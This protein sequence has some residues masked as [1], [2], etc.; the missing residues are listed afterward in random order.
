MKIGFFTDGYLPQLNGVATSVEAW[1][2]GLGK[3]GHE[4]YII[5]PKYQ[6]FKDKSDYEYY[7][8]K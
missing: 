6:N 1:S 8:K 2:K 5:A 7:F 4:V 3:L